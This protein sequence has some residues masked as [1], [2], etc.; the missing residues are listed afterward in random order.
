ML[1]WDISFTTGVSVEV[2]VEPEVGSVWPE[3]DVNSAYLWAFC[4]GFFYNQW[5]RKWHL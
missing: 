3:V 4:L 1:E 5:E 2:Q